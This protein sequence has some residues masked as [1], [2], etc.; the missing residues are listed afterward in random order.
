[1]TEQEDQERQRYLEQ[2]DEATKQAAQ[3]LL[4]E[5]PDAQA[6]IVRAM[7]RNAPWYMKMW[8]VITGRRP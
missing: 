3:R 1:M 8:W 5:Y 4:E 6:V 2:L 7:W